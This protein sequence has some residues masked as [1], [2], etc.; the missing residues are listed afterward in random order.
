MTKQVEF[1][2]DYGAETFERVRS[3]NSA[4]QL[5]DVYA[6]AAHS[7]MGQT[8]NYTGLPY[9][10]H[11]RMV[12]GLL[13]T[14]KHS[15]KSLT[16]LVQA[17][18]LHDVVEDTEITI[19]DLLKV[20][21]PLVVGMVEELTEPD[22][23]DY[24]RRHG[25]DKRPPRKERR[26]I[27]AQRRSTI[28][29]DAQ[30][31]SVADIIANSHDIVAAAPRDFARMYQEELSYRLDMLKEADPALWTVARLLVD[32]NLAKLGPVMISD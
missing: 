21:D 22:D 7:A 18:L 14:T 25:F 28:S 1:L 20:F 19:D 17:A 11:P 26:R 6:D 15:E 31:I 3:T 27:E 4:I 29:A 24:W 16:P 12:A 2:I 8:R 30:T 13:Y 9:I 32:E 10:V 23:P 5:A